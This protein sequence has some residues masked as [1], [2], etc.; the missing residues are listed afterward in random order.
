MIEFSKEAKEEI[1]RVLENKDLPSDIHVRVGI[2]G[3]ACEG[4]LVFGLDKLSSGDEIYTIDE[5]PVLIAQKHLMYVLGAKVDL[6]WQGEKPIFLVS[7][8]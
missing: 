2:K 4:S 5:I 1:L 3:N 7:S 6:R 8:H